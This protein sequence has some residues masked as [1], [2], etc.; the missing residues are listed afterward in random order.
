M[1][2]KNDEDRVGLAA[3]RCGLKLI[4]NRYRVAAIDKS[5]RRYCL[6]LVWDAS[7]F[8][9][10]APEGGYGLVRTNMKGWK[11]GKAASWL[12]LPAVEQMLRDWRPETKPRTRARKYQRHPLTISGAR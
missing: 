7:R 12:P 4:R 5:D 6:R 11:R 10:R 8:V 9:G 1:A 3:A 2:E